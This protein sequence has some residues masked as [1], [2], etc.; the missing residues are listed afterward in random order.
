MRGIVPKFGSVMYIPSP[1]VRGALRGRLNMKAALP[2]ASA[3]MVAASL[4]VPVRLACA[5]Q[6]SDQRFDF[7]VQ[8]G[9]NTNHFVRVGEV[10]AHLVLRAGTDPRILIAFPAG[11]SGVGVWFLPQRAKVSWTLSGQPR[12]LYRVDEH[13]RAL[14]GI[15]ADAIAVAQ[16]LEIRQA[17]L[18]S[19]RV[20]RDF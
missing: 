9:L 4:L 17:V 7:E 12:A 5:L 1:V 3:L 16:D 8:E 6:P 18:S 19:I 11:N 14:Y 13:G 20:L 10:A 2:V 15:S